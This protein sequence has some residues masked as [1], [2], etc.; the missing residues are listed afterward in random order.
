M[1]MRMPVNFDPRRYLGGWDS[2]PMP[3]REKL[4]DYYCEGYVE[5]G[6]PYGMSTHS[7]VIWLEEQKRE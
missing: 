1:N 3:I 5:A 6:M 4:W 7:V 2:D